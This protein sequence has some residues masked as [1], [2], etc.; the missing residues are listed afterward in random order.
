MTLTRKLR[1][2]SFGFAAAAAP[3]DP[4]LLLALQEALRARGT[5]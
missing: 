1:F 4:S 2:L 5:R 3:H